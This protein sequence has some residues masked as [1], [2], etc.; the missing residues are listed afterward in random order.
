MRHGGV[1][2]MSAVQNTLLVRIFAGATLLAF[3]WAW[4]SVSMALPFPPGI[5]PNSPLASAG[6]LDATLYAGVDP[7]GISDSTA[8]LQQALDDGHNYAMP[9]YLPSGTYLVSDTL[10][11]EQIF[12]PNCAQFLTF[13]PG[14]DIPKVHHLVGAKQPTRPRIVLAANS[15]GFAD[16]SNPKAV[17][18]FRNTRTS[19][20]MGGADC[21]FGMAVRNIHIEIRAGNPGAVGLQIPSAQW[22]TVEDVR[23]DA[24]GAYAG[25]RG[26]VT[27][28]VMVNVEVVGGR[29]GLIADTCCG[30]SL[31]GLR[32]RD[33]TEAGLWV[34]SPGTVTVTGFDIAPAQGPA[35]LME[36]GYQAGQLTLYD[37]TLR[38]PNAA[39]PAI[40]NTYE[41][42]VY[43]G[44]VYVDAPGALIAS[45]SSTSVV[46]P[47]GWQRVAEYSYTDPAIAFYPPTP[48]PTRAFTLIDGVVSQN[49]RLTLGTAGPPSSD[50]IA[51]HVW[52]ELPRFTDPGVKNVLDADVGAVGDGIVDDTDALQAALD[53]HEKL[54]LPRGRYRI[55]RPLVLHANT[56]LFGIT[57]THSR[58][59]ATWDPDG[60]FEHAVRTDADS[61]GSTYL[62]DLFIELGAGY[63]QSYLGAIDWRVGRNSLLRQVFMEPDW[64][65]ENATAPR[66]MAQIVGGGGR[67]Y[68]LTNFSEH[69][70]THADFRRVLIT[71]TQEPITLYGP[72]LEH[73]RGDATIEVLRSANVRIFG[74]KTEDR[75][76]ALFNESSNILFAGL[77]SSVE[78]V[79]A[80]VFNDTDDVLGPNLTTYPARETA[81]AMVLENFGGSTFF[82]AGTDNASLFRRGSFDPSVF[83]GGVAIATPVQGTVFTPGQ[84]VTATGTGNDLHWDFD[85]IGDGLGD[86]ADGDGPSVT[87]TVPADS[88]AS[89]SILIKL[90]GSGGYAERTYAIGAGGTVGIT[91]PPLGTVFA[92]GQVVT[93]TGTGN[94]LHWD[95]DR[96]G[97]GLGDFADGDGPSVTFTVPADSTT[98]QTIQITLTGTEGTDQRTYAISP[99]FAVTIDSVSTGQP[100]AIAEAQVGA[101]E[102]IDRNY[103][104]TS[105]SG[106]LAGGT[107]IQAA[108]DDKFVAA[109]SHLSFTVSTAASVYVAWDSRVVGL[110]AWLDGSWTLTGE[111]YVSD[112]GSAANVYV[113][114]VA[115][116]QVTLGG[117]LASPAQAPA[118]GHSHYA[119][120]VK[121]Q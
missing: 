79:D 30:I 117:T 86:F 43:L 47:A 88:T 81:G 97:D 98:S 118:N 91:S 110:P 82:L 17:V 24:S 119:V 40:V 4:P 38:M 9:V 59:Y 73:A 55:S 69:R 45:G 60:E 67:W 32:L 31:V 33:Q 94:D 52:S 7:T 23:I 27:T 71:D 13:T 93:A 89:Q 20:W 34:T 108:N 115:A 5:S 15:P 36:V 85:R 80:V 54:F 103:T 102:F 22:S 99:A 116:G 26:A 83:S 39:S 19:D 66:K 41:G 18:H 44:N 105:L 112:G 87:F 74:T 61:A 49:E 106:A 35:V 25:I 84:T 28:N 3:L 63:E 104:I 111:T 8:G 109:N 100:Y 78:P 121:P 101:F 29:I 65:D 51:R 11:G 56:K 16:P 14:Y 90:T 12:T 58:L 37:G 96:I 50:L 57:G 46:I 10:R 107:L 62:A 21:A 2:A 95:F 72:N 77:T 53:T 42:S 92:P 70:S 64:E 6:Y 114:N 1:S 48:S 113:K 75:R 76:F 68:G 120:I